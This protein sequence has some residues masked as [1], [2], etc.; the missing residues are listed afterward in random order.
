MKLQE[1]AEPSG[2]LVSPVVQLGPRRFLTRCTLYLEKTFTIADME[3]R[4]LRHDPTE[5][6]TR[7]V[8]PALWLLIF[9]EVFT[10][11]HAIPTGGL[12]YLDFMAPGIL[13]QSVLFIAIF[14]GI[15][16]IWER[17]L[18][19]VHKF[20]AGPIPRTALVLGKSL[21]A[22]VRGLSQAL[23]IYLLALVLGVHLSWNP[24]ALLGVLAFVLLGAACFSTFSLIITSQAH[25]VD[26][27]RLPTR[28]PAVLHMAVVRS[29]YAHAAITHVSLDR[30]MSLPG[31][32]AAFSGADLVNDL[33]LLANAVPVLG[34]KCFQTKGGLQRD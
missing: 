33:R 17:D 14:S 1:H 19:L 13:A 16:I 18:G 11:T 7:A 25:F 9:G 10:R 22:G 26:D 23:I 32:A 21:A 5:L 2:G 12:P 30:A 20:L 29:P 15:A 31:V 34:L 6:V 4:K 24:L 3:V 27:V 28:R 8:Q